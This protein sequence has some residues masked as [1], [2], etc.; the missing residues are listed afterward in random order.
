[1]HL[2]NYLLIRSFTFPLSFL[3][4]STIHYTWETYG[5]LAYFLIPKYRKKALS[6]LSLA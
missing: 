5:V 3:A 2:I 6:N 1:M 4:Y